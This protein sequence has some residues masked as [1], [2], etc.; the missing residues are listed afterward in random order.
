M[1]WADAF[2]LAFVDGGWVPSA[3]NASHRDCHYWWLLILRQVLRP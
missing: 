3:W 2:T 1:K